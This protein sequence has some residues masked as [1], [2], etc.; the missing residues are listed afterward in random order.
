MT[1]QRITGPGE[2]ELPKFISSYYE[3]LKADYDAVQI[4]LER[5]AGKKEAS[6][7]RSL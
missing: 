5:S 7:I 4:P 2:A 6:A 3:R 1:V